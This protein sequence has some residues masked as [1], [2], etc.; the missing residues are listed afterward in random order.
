MIAKGRILCV[1]ALGPTDDMQETF[2]IQKANLAEQIWKTVWQLSIRPPQQS[3][4]KRS[5]LR[6]I[7]GEN[8]Q[9]RC[10]QSG[11]KR[12]DSL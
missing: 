12:A 1:V 5:G 9:K 6:A 8:T 2:E 7:C 10:W 11:E 4:E 3:L